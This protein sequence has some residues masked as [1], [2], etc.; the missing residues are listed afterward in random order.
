LDLE[1]RQPIHS[2]F[3][4][5]MG[6]LYSIGDQ[7]VREVKPHY[8]NMVKKILQEPWYCELERQ[9]K[10][11][12]SE[13]VSSNEAS[14]GGSSWL[15]HPK[16]P[17]VTY[18]WEWSFSALKDAAMLTLE[19]ELKAREHGYT[20][21]DSTG[22]N[23]LFVGAHPMFVD[24]LSFVPL[25]SGAPWN[26]LGQFCRAFLFPL[27][28]Q[29]YK[30]LSP[31]PLLL[32][33]LGE[34]GLEDTWRIL[35]LSSIRR[36]GVFKWV[37]LQRMLEKRMSGSRLDGESLKIG[38]GFLD[39]QQ[40]KRMILSLHSLINSIEWNPQNT[41]WATYATENSYAEEEEKQKADFVEGIL[42]QLQPDRVFDFGANSGVYSRIA[43]KH[44]REVFSLDHDPGAIDLLQRSKVSNIW[45]I[46]G[47]LANPTPG[48]GWSST[49]RLP[50]LERIGQGFFLAL[51]LIHHLRISCGIPLD[52]V[53]ALFE[54]V[55]CSGIIEWVDRDDVMVKH[56]LKHREDVFDDYEK[57]NFLKLIQARFNIK[58]SV[59]LRGGTRALYW[60]D[61]K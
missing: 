57:S 41:E 20:L 49:E 50:L 12:I 4:D 34:I 51:A 46:L 19:I 5:P 58:L 52:N 48:V 42:R 8:F 13:E 17:L 26:A 9:G 18:P 36:P 29:S 37:Y 60:I 47:N 56:L 40:T 7:L 11:I 53:I 35:G 3:R 30:N 61:R 39:D 10:L 33:G 16:L 22:T 25:K 28:I 23:I 21:K 31:Q 6:R 15:K 44:V 27:M 1:L 14:K 24:V 2:S 54:K 59:E 43:S 45:S 55:G 38:D 32:S